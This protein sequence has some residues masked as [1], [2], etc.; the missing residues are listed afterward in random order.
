MLVMIAVLPFGY[1]AYQISQLSDDEQVLNEIYQNQLNAVLGSVNQYSIDLITSWSLRTAAIHDNPYLSVGQKQKEQVKLCTQSGILSAVFFSDLENEN[2]LY[3]DTT[4]REFFKFMIQLRDQH[5]DKAEKLI[6]YKKAGYAKMDVLKSSGFKQYLPVM[7]ALDT[8]ALSTTKIG[9]LMIDAEQ[10]ISQGLGPKMQEVAGDKFVVST[11]RKEDQELVF[12]TDP[13][14]TITKEFIAKSSLLDFWILPDFQLGITPKGVSLAMLAKERSTNQ[15]LVLGGISILLIVSMIFLYFNVR[16]EA[17]LSQAKS[18]FVSNV[19]HELRTPLSLISMFAET[20]E[21][22]RVKTEEK[23]NEYYSIIRKETERLSK[24]VSSILSFSQMDANKKSYQFE[25]FNLVEVCQ[26]VY[27]HYAPQL[28]ENGFEF[29][30][31]K[32]DDNIPVHIDKEA[33]CEAVINLLDNATKYSQST[34]QVSLRLYTNNQLAKLEVT[35]RGMG[36]PKKHHKEI[37]EQFFRT[38]GNNVHNTKGSGLGLAIV[39]KIIKAHH[40]SIEL[41]SAPGK[42]STF[43]ISLPLI[44][45]NE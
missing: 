18:E 19:S 21:L 3:S 27:D 35:D 25:D 10:F 33:I 28:R 15:L 8:S 9:I 41:E 14:L 42:G 5:I 11:I 2:I 40:G 6:R 29:S 13:H 30:F 1:I 34:K 31:E 45:E 43:S 32:T 7:F 38:P 24:I 17:Y 20:L 12:A 23:K 36:I 37:F 22:G 16:R 44:S 26:E 4:D 39:S